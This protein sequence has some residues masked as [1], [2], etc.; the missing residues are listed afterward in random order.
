MRLMLNQALALLP[1]QDPA[2]ASAFKGMT[3]HQA[4]SLQQ[5]LVP[6]LAIGCAQSTLCE[7]SGVAAAG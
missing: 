5:Q 7:G 3:R 6:R 1:Q 2:E 4:V